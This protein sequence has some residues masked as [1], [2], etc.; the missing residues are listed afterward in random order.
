MSINKTFE[1]QF[2]NYSDYTENTNSPLPPPYSPLHKR[3]YFEMA[4][5]SG[6]SKKKAKLEKNNR[7][8]E[9]KERGS[10]PSPNSKAILELEKMEKCQP[11][12][13]PDKDDDHLYFTASTKKIL[14]YSDDS[15]PP[16]FATI[17]TGNLDPHSIPKD[18]SE[19][20]RANLKT[21]R[22][23]INHVKDVA[24]FSVNLLQRSPI[25]STGYYNNNHVDTLHKTLR[26]VRNRLALLD[27]K[28]LLEKTLKYKTG[29][30]GELSLVGLFQDKNVIRVKIING[31]HVLLIVDCEM[32]DP[33][34]YKNLGPNAAI[35]DP[36]SG[37]SYP[38]SELK[39][40]LFDYIGP[41]WVDEMR[42][43]QV[44]RFDPS[45]QTLA[46]AKQ[47]RAF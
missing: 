43:T 14:L 29:N 6:Q 33:L 44:A 26:L 37:A 17:L 4:P 34:N 23:I 35:C 25:F 5:S 42:Y 39:K 47:W 8:N 11:S 15:S 18:A 32:G 19:E 45:K 13:Y 20:L 16:E 28:E 12:N 3:C 31:N 10:M 2:T 38:A 41:V 36:W 27:P 22:E 46:R 30:C 40:Y 9:D 21:A 1:K 7:G 24:P